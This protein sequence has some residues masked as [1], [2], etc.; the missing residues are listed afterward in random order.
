MSDTQLVSDPNDYLRDYK[1]LPAM[2]PGSHRHMFGDGVGKHGRSLISQRGFYVLPGIHSLDPAFTKFLIELSTQLDAHIPVDV[3]QDGFS[4]SGVHSDFGR[5]K[6]AAG[7]LMSPMSYVAVDNSEYV[8]HLGLKD[9]LDADEIAIGEE[10][11]DIVW[12]SYLPSKIKVTKRSAGGVRR[13]TSDHEWKKAYGEYVLQPKVL[14]RILNLHTARDVY[15]LAN[16]FEMLFLMESQ[17]RAQPDKVGKDREAMDLQYAQT[18]GRE[19]NIVIADKT[20][21]DLDGQPIPELSAARARFVHAGPWAVNCILSM[22]STGTLQALFELFPKTWHVNTPDE[23]KAVIDGAFVYASDV[24]EYDRSM[25]KEH[26][27]LP[28]RVGRKYWS[29]EL[30]DMAEHLAFSSYYAKPLIAD[31]H[32]V[33]G[34]PHEGVIIGDYTSFDPQVVCGNRSGHAFT[35]LLA[36]VNKVWETLYVLHKIGYPIKGRVRDYLNHNCSFFTVNN[37]D[38]SLDCSWD[39]EWFK[40][41]ASVRD[42]DVPF[43][44]FVVK[45]EAGAVYSGYVMRIDAPGSRIYHP[46]GRLSTAFEKMYCPERSIDDPMRKYAHI[47]IAQR[48]NDRSSHP[49]AEQAWEIHD[50]LYRDL[51]APRFGSL[52]GILSDMALKAPISTLGRSLADLAV[53]DDHSKLYYKF[54]DGEVSDEVV[55]LSTIS[56][57][58]EAFMESVSIHYSGNIIERKDNVSEINY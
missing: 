38:D 18:G 36:K 32:D 37:G 52:Y 54:K 41:Y 29:S 16:E 4:Q 24:T 47:G 9:Q 34:F 14:S 43:G 40:K 44:S 53:L 35:S 12:S 11:W 42:D 39:E 31:G 33:P 6:T 21:R 58:P 20:V 2:K 19:G 3:D 51:L 55:A 25:R 26:I 10:L 28:L 45:R 1:P 22:I 46:C 27:C 13:N 17:K 23:I 56:I 5:I 8:K 49:A 7:V 50:K 48:I 57:P 15:A 30:M